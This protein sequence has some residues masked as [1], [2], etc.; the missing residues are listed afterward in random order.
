MPATKENSVPNTILDEDKKGQEL[1]DKLA[2]CSWNKE[3]IN[4]KDM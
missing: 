3:P 4:E 2:S 1:A